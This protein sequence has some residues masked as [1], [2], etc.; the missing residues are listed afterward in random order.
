MPRQ[1]KRERIVYTP[2]W[3]KEYEKWVRGFVNVHSWRVD[4][5]Y[6]PDDL[7]QEA[8]I[9][10]R[11]LAD[12]YPRL[13]D[14][15]HF[16]ALFKRAVINKMN[17]RSCY[18]NRRKNTVE[19]PISADIYDL[20]V[21]R[22]GEM[23]NNGYLNVLLNEMPDEMKLAVAMLTDENTDENDPEVVKKTALLNAAIK[24]LLST[25]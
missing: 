11:H 18:Y 4:P 22:I 5:M 8:Y 16:M 14:P 6:G 7:V 20:F 3:C 9:T 21:G 15:Q 17:D 19:A 2:T 23:T 1:R 24:Q 10:F 13:M 12:R 25:D